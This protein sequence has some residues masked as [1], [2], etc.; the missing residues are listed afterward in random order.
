M[1][2]GDLR[3]LEFQSRQLD[4]LF[5]FAHIAQVRLDGM[6]GER[7]FQHQVSFEAF[8]YG[9]PVHINRAR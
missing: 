3:R 4:E 2:G 5:Q 8:E 9:W 7:A 1:I 6:L